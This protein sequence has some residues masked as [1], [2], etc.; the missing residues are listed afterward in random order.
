MQTKR[1]QTL[2]LVGTTVVAIALLFANADGYHNELSLGPRSS[3][4]FFA[5]PPNINWTHGWP[6]KFVNRH[7]IYSVDAGKGVFVM[8]FTGDHGL[9][10]RWPVD[11]APLRHFQ[12]HWLMLD[13]AVFILLLAGTARGL[14]II[15]DRLRLRVQFGIKHLF[16]LLTVLSVCLALRQQLFPSRFVLQYAAFAVIAAGI[17]LVVLACLNAALRLMRLLRRPSDQ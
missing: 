1:D 13:V 8:S 10:N 14:T 11:N 7:G 15:A 9:Y 6:V 5:E 17:M 2:T 16:A 3:V 12:L 4:D